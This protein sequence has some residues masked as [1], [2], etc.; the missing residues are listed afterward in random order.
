MRRI[1]E[2][3]KKQKCFN[4]FIVLIAFFVFYKCYYL[5]NYAVVKDNKIYSGLKF[6]DTITVKNK[7]YNNEEYFIYNNIKLLNKFQEFT[8]TEE[9]DD[10]VWYSLNKNNTSASFGISTYD[11]YTKILKTDSKDISIY[12]GANSS[13]EVVDKWLK[14]SRKDFF[15]KN[16]IKDDLGLF[17]YLAKKDSFKSNILTPISEMKQNYAINSMI[18]VI[19]PS[20]NS[21]TEIKGDLKGYIFNLSKYKEVSI[22]KGDKRYILSFINLD[23]FT[24]EY[25]EEI[26]N[27]LIIS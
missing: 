18:N 3:T 11:S 19:M 13:E 15:T 16:N 24:P 7:K 4:F 26:L 1:G 2:L 5:Y 14:I 12:T 23:Y 10:F 25:I 17:K 20:V 27:S 21:L 22:I 6:T 8:K 9:G